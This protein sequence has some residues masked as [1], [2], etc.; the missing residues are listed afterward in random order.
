MVHV[1]RHW[2]SKKRGHVIMPLK[3]IITAWRLILYTLLTQ[4][5][6]CHNFP[7]VIGKEAFYAIFLQLWMKRRSK[8][9]RINQLTVYYKH[10]KSEHRLIIKTR[11]KL[12]KNSSVDG[13]NNIRVS[14]DGNSF[15]KIQRWVGK[16]CGSISF[17]KKIIDVSVDQ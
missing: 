9:L 13:T 8:L 6:K 4:I 16:S 15:M 5:W 12:L 10:Y 1:L 7:Q 2:F 11:S 17:L 3:Y 14:S